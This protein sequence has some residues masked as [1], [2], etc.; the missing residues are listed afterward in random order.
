MSLGMYIASDHKLTTPPQPES[1]DLLSL[2][3]LK[4]WRITPQSFQN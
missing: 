4:N 1:V 2:N 3:D